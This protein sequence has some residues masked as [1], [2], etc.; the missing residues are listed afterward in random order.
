M[1]LV[2]HYE[3]LL[4]LIVPDRVHVLAGGRIVKSG[5]KELARELDERG[6]D[7]IQAGGTRV[8]AGT[9]PLTAG[10]TVP[11][12]EPD[13]RRAPRRA[14]SARRGG[15]ADAAARALALHG[16]RAAR[17]RRLRA[18]S[19]APRSR[20]TRRRRA[21]ACSTTR[22]SAT[23]AATRAARWS[24]ASPASARPAIAGIDVTDL[25]E[26][27]GE[28]VRLFAKPIS[29]RTASA[30]GAEHGVR[31]PRRSGSGCRPASRSARRFISCSSARGRELAA[32]P[33]IVIEVGPARRPRSCS[34]SSTAT[35]TRKAGPTASRS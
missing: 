25:E 24:S 29:A 20:P 9:I 15:L 19:R 12:P 3:R 33:R 32:Q 26:R 35:R 1:L 10:A 21:S 7:W 16:P 23:V 18:R 11:G 17:D 6:Y 27:W 2:T 14:R 28:F 13:A 4:E 22:R 34:T 8:N 31:P 30:R 5:D